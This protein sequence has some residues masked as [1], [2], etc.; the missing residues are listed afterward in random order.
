VALADWLRVLLLSLLWGSAF[1]HIEIA[2]RDV[3]PL[4]IVLTRLSL[5]A[6]ALILYCFATGA[7]I[8]ALRPLIGS[9]LV[10][11]VTAT[12]LPF[13]LIALGQT[14][15]TSGLASMFI[16]ST[17]L[18]TVLVAHL[19]G[20]AEPATPA[21]LSGVV[22][23][24]AGVGVLMG[25]DVLAGLSGS[26]A[27]QI[28]MLG[29]ALCYA[30]A[31]VFGRRFRDVPPP[32]T[33]AGMLTSASLVIAPVA[34]ALETPFRPLPGPAA[35]AS[36]TAL[37]LLST[38]LAY[39]LYFRILASAG[40]TNAMLVTLVQPP[41]AILLGV[42]FLG[43]R[44]EWNQTGGLALILAGLLLVDGRIVRMATGRA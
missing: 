4:T 44:L 7:R 29:A 18:I 8:P 40:S 19:W 35:F 3:G 16:A 37:A 42:L 26:A 30:I 36:M 15:I 14:R 10:M 43:E 20:R 1:F 28:A 24:L 9:F 11:G 38:S 2:L 32:V 12:A 23:G 13:S 34:F 21:K 33:A 41:L 22:I 17:P 39:I 31:A 6:T 5:A 27:G 25:P